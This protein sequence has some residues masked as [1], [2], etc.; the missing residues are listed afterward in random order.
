[1]QL[2]SY[3]FDDFAPLPGSGVDNFYTGELLRD[4]DGTTF[5]M[6]GDLGK[7]GYAIHRNGK[8]DKK[9]NQ[10][11]ALFQ[12]Y[13]VGSDMVTKQPYKNSVFLVTNNG[14]I[15]IWWRGMWWH[16][17]KDNKVEADLALQALSKEPIFGTTPE[18]QAAHVLKT[19]PE[20]KEGT[21]YKWYEYFVASLFSRRMEMPEILSN[22]KRV[23]EGVTWGQWGTNYD[24][25]ARNAGAFLDRH[26]GYSREEVNAKWGTRLHESQKGVFGKI[27]G[28]IVSGFLAGG[29][30]G[31]IIGGVGGVVTVTKVDKALRDQA[32]AEAK[33]VQ[34][35]VSQVKEATAAKAEAEQKALQASAQT[36]A[37]IKNPY[38]IG[39]I[40]FILGMVILLIRKK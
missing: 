37:L 24:K 1:M 9:V 12:A 15:Y 34:Q 23:D 36:L 6:T 8:Y 33:T 4:P 29:P 18:Q 11:I 39:A 32:A 3:A 10:G 35:T 28:G 21:Y 25:A 16:Y 2:D 27:I 31:A 13:D 19:I 17:V 22:K 7:W 14:T 20:P 38:V 40:L 26:A 5:Q 30:V